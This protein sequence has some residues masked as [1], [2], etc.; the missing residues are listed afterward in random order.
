MV[1]TKILNGIWPSFLSNSCGKSADLFRQSK[2]AARSRWLRPNQPKSFFRAGLRSYLVP[3]RYR[4]YF[5]CIPTPTGTKNVGINAHRAFF[6]ANNDNSYLGELTVAEKVKADLRS[7]RDEMR[8]TITSGFSNWATVTK[9]EELF[10]AVALATVFAYDEAPVLQPKFRMQG[11]WAYHTLNCTTVEPP[12]EIDLDDGMFL[13]VSFLGQNGN[14]H[15]AVVSHTYFATVER[16]LSPLCAKRGWTLV[17]D[18]PSCVR[19][20]VY[21]GAHV[22]IALYAIPDRDFQS[23]VEKAAAASVFAADEVRNS[24]SFSDA[25]YRDIPVDHIM[26]AHRTDGWIPS[27]PRKL[28]DW[29]QEGIEAYGQQLRRVCRYLKGWRDN[30]WDACRLSS[31]AL[32]ACAMTA[33]DQAGAARPDQNRDDKALLMVARRLPGL[34][35]SAI[36]NPVVDGMVLNDNWT[37]E[38]RSS[39]VAGAN[40]LVSVLERA[41]DASTTNAALAVLRDEFGDY[42]PNDGSLLA[43]DGVNQ[44]PSILTTGLLGSLGANP[45]ARAAVK[46]GGDD[47]YG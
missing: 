11:S 12:Q 21:D 28:D 46:R 31:I 25:L 34:F 9:R 8:E 38:C 33:F 32:M 39:F 14:S 47:R 18:K 13:P 22:D 37:S 24:I 7:V 16:L 19:V 40:R 27:D 2:Q 17:R 35:A 29:F 23:L 5:Q 4:S 6:S 3:C 15:P 30:N 41:L 45:D 44:A 42:L 36:D 10:E 20:A 1:A 26:L 43:L